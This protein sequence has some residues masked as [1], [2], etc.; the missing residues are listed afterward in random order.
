[1]ES[2]KIGLQRLLGGMMEH[3]SCYI[4]IVRETF[5]QFD[6]SE[7]KGLEIVRGFETVTVELLSLRHVNWFRDMVV[8]DGYMTPSSPE[9]LSEGFGRLRA[10]LAV[11]GFLDSVAMRGLGQELNI[12]DTIY[13]NEGST[14]PY[15]Y[16]PELFH[17][18]DAMESDE[19]I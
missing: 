17:V 11:K 6:S 18:I 4:R 16:P 2:A 15:Q 13:I 10:T 14:K 7:L 8:E 1:M 19:E 5:C 9:E 12:E 3:Q